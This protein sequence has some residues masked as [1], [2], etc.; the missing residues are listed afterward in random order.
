MQLTSSFTLLLES[1]LAASLPSY[2]TAA[3]IDSNVGIFSFPLILNQL[4]ADVH[5]GVSRRRYTRMMANGTETTT[6]SS[7]RDNYAVRRASTPLTTPPTTP[8]TTPPVAPPAAPPVTPPAIA[9]DDP[10]RDLTLDEQEGHEYATDIT[11]AVTPKVANMV[12]LSIEGV[13]DGYIA[14]VQIGMPPR[15]FK[16]LMDSGSADLWVGSEMCQSTVPLPAGKPPLRCGKHVFLG[17]KT[18]TSFK[19]IAGSKWKVS[20]GTGKVT[21]MLVTDN[22]KI[23]TLALPN[24]PFGVAKTET[25]DFTDAVLDG[26][27]GVAQSISARQGQLNIVDSLFKQKLI[28]RPVVL[29]KISR[30]ADK[31]NDGQI[32]FSGLDTTKFDP[33][34]LV[35]IPN[36][37]RL[38][39]WEAAVDVVTINGKALAFTGGAHTTVMDIGSNFIVMPPADATALNAALG[40]RTDAAGDLF[41]PCNTKAQLA[42]TI[43]KEAFTIDMRDLVVDDPDSVGECSSI[44]SPEADPVEDGNPNGWLF[45]AP[46]L[47]N[48]YLLLDMQANT[49]EL[50]KLV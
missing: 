14:L 6:P 45:G 30:L 25:K 50:A 37:S 3:P 38:G 15:N 32:T 21:G 44:I 8:L 28:A 9:A 2:V 23:G 17:P 24:H 48:V 19:E 22:V 20:Y 5:P 26:L 10:I 31:K 34:T 1:V 41:L 7:L 42:V 43:S 36:V 49:I 35:S 46:F 40:G 4:R 29:F 13:D 33:K 18:S 12:G 39:L 27:L 11:P 47:K 16:L